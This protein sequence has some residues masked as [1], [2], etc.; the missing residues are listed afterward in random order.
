MAKTAIGQSVFLEAAPYFLVDDVFATAE[1][2]RDKLGFHFDTFFGEPP[3]FVIVKRNTT[4]MMFR[5]GPE[6]RRPAARSNVELLPHA[7]DAYI[8]VSDVDGLAAELKGR[9]ADIVNGPHDS[10]G[11]PTR[12]ELLVRD[13]NGYVLCFGRVLGWPE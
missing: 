8:W 11:G 1:Y 7:L 2:Y 13:L 6:A 9:G 3:A 12:R 10:D 4:R 5:Q